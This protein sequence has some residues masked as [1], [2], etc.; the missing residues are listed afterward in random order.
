MHVLICLPR[1][2]APPPDVYSFGIVMHEVATFQLPWAA[3]NTWQIVSLVLGGGRPTVPP[4]EQL[5][6]ADTPTFAGLDAFL[7][8]M[9]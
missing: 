2:A 7:A 1:L 5:P 3:S 4:R 6:G 9:R 8:L